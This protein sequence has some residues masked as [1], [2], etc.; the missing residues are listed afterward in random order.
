MCGALRRYY[1]ETKNE[2]L[3]QQLGVMHSLPKKAHPLTELVNHWGVGLFRVPII[4]EDP[5]ERLLATELGFQEYLAEGVEEL[6]HLHMPIL[7]WFPSG[8]LRK[9]F[10]LNFGTGLGFTSVPG[11]G[12]GGAVCGKEVGGLGKVFGFQWGQTGELFV[13]RFFWVAGY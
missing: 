13:Y 9:F 3:P 5:L 4:I 6:L 10:N 7:G 1:L 11:F 8:L 2:P 12:G